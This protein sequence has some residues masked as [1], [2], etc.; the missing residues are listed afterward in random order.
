MT[1]ET[2]VGLVV[3][4]GII[5]LIGI[6]V[7]DHLST[8]NREQP[9]TVAP[10]GYVD[11]TPNKPRVIDPAKSDR[12]TVTDRA[13]GGQPGA[14]PRDNRGSEGNS[15]GARLD[16]GA[17]LQ[18][19]DD[20]AKNAGGGTITTPPGS[21]GPTIDQN[22]AKA[23][24]ER[25][26]SGAEIRVFPPGL[27]AGN[28]GVRTDGAGG[29]S[30]DARGGISS[31]NGNGNGNAGATEGGAVTPPGGPSVALPQP[32]IHYTQ[33]RETLWSLSQR[34]YGDG[35]YFAVIAKANPDKLL[36]NGGVRDGVRLVIPNKSLVVP[37]PSGATAG[38]TVTA[39]ANPGTP[40]QPATPAARTVK[41]ES[42][43]TLGE[44][45]FK[46]LGSSRLT[47]QIIEANKDQIRDANDIKIGMVLK[48]PAVTTPAPGNGTLG[49]SLRTEGER[50][51]D[52]ASTPGGS[53]PGGPATTM[54]SYKV[55]PGDTF[56]SIARTRLGSDRRW[57]ELFELNRAKVGDPENLRDGMVLA[58]PA[59][60]R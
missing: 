8:Q 35:K 21:G 55:Q 13:D 36:A 5:L 47:N 44:I 31:G 59:D 46:H 25:H 29:T 34:Y 1:R 10:P 3:G 18:H 6:I 4:T 58:L 15:F 26:S 54:K 30:A 39:P 7:S 24:A 41:V 49:P 38:G 40:G 12:A 23:L 2:K 42:G 17:S 50:R 33:P 16:K 27:G 56:T 9:R 11:A 57:K 43:D 52:G 32:S 37:A 48:L 51:T 22:L 14:S 28:E 53:S 19:V 45:A 20:A 60:A